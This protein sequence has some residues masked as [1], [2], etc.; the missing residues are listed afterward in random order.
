MAGYDPVGNTL[1]YNYRFDRN[2]V[3]TIVA[4]L[5]TEGFI[6][7]GWG[8]GKHGGLDITKGSFVKSCAARYKL[9][10]TRVPGNLTRMRGLKRGDILVTPHLPSYGKVSMHVVADDFPDCYQYVEDDEIHQN[11]RVKIAVSFGLN[12]EVSIRHLA[13]GSWYAKLQWLRL[14]LIPI[15]QHEAAFKQVIS[16]L[17][18]SPE[19]IF[20]PSKMEEYLASL[21]SDMV[22]EL[23]KKL[24]ELRPSGTKVSFEA[25]CE[26]LLVSSG[27]QIVRRNHYDGQGGDVDLHCERDRSYSSPFEAGQTTLFVQVKKHTG[28]TDAQAVRQVLAMIEREPL[29]DGCV[30]SLGDSF[31][32]EAERLAEENGTILLS[33]DT[34]C[35]LLLQEIGNQAAP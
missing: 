6:S 18:A 1:I 20:Q 24:Q 10:T 27:Y 13:V 32:E 23:N 17:D 3:K 29:A 21:H 11:H 34:I 2:N 35:R 9:T 14:P 26:R 31:T 5:S 19:I 28:R 16:Q 22:S 15:P 33:G 30:M 25:I 8:G 7:Q 12:G 4:R